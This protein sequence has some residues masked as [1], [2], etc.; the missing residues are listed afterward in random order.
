MNIISIINEEIE[1]WNSNERKRLMILSSSLF[2]E[3]NFAADSY[4]KKDGGNCKLAFASSFSDKFSKDKSSS[5]Q[6]KKY[7]IVLSNYSFFDDNFYFSSSDW[8]LIDRR[9]LRELFKGQEKENILE[10][11]KREYHL[12]DSSEL[13][14]FLSGQQ[15]FSAIAQEIEEKLKNKK[16]SDSDKES[17]F[18]ENFLFY[19]ESCDNEFCYCEHPVC[20]PQCS[21]FLEQALFHVENCFEKAEDAEN[22][23]NVF[24]ADCN[25][26]NWEKRENASNSR[27]SSLDNL[28]QPIQ[29]ST[30]DQEIIISDQISSINIQLTSDQITDPNQISQI[31]KEGE[32]LQSDHPNF[33]LRKNLD[34]AL[35]KL[36]EIDPIK[37]RQN[38][39]ILIDEKLKKAQLQWNIILEQG[40]M[41]RIEQLKNGAIVDKDAII[42]AKDEIFQEIEDKI[43]KKRSNL[44][45]ESY[46]KKSS[47]LNYFYYLIFISLGAIILIAVWKW[48]KKKKQESNLTIKH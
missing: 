41:F 35:K 44:S 4:K 32:K 39:I 36:F 10:V 19:V 47:L 21:N 20:V 18:G 15:K 9:Q 38:I 3:V 34:K 48:A 31:I 12:L 29:I 26:I 43:K 30:N 1:K 40:T 33:D 5:D 6:E 27:A 37:A 7:K 16:I 45:V 17:I 14:K 42:S 24:L 23:K 46:H 25:K 22:F 13:N 8:L 11:N 28:S 2:D